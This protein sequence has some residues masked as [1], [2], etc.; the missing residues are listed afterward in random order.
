VAFLEPIREAIATR[1]PKADLTSQDDFL[2]KLIF[3]KGDIV[4]NSVS[5]SLR[6]F[7][8]SLSPPSLH[9]VDQSIALVSVPTL[10]FLTAT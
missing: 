10:S 4:S 7:F 3:H 1:F 8:L 6:S 5:L 2:K 9:T